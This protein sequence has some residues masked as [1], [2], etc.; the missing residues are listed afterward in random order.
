M[1]DILGAISR[2]KIKEASCVIELNSNI[3]GR[4]IKYFFSQATLGIIRNNS[5]LAILKNKSNLGIERNES[6]LA[7]IK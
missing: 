2:V 3:S 5:K 6:K 7:I 1:T 4:L